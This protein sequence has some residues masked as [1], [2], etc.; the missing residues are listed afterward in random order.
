MPVSE[1]PIARPLLGEEEAQAAARV[2]RSGWVMQG[3]EVT[4]F[5]R[6]LAAFVGG[7]HACAVSSGTAA[8]HLALRAAGVGPGDEVVTVSHSVI[9]TA[10]SIALCGAT[11]VFVDIE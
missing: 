11:P 3:P 2:V 7:A 1:I 10:N 8:L 6:E 5:E 9:A 4:E